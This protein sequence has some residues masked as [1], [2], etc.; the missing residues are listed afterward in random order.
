[1]GVEGAEFDVLRSSGQTGEAPYFNLL[2]DLA[3]VLY[4]D[5]HPHSLYARGESVY[6]FNAWL[7][8]KGYWVL[9]MGGT[10]NTL[11]C[12]HE[13]VWPSMGWETDEATYS[14][15]YCNAVISSTSLAL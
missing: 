12:V 1:M 4:I 2:A 7:Q 15:R 10:G 9:E 13:R 3:D 11:I 6:A 8:H 5:L 14:C